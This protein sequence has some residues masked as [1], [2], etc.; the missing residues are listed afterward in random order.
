LQ[1]LP[2]DAL[3]PELRGCAD[4]PTAGLGPIRFV[5]LIGL[6]FAL[7]GLYFMARILRNAAWL[8]GTTL[9]VRAVADN[10]LIHHL[11]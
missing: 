9:R 10:P 7:I 4:L 11:Q 8:D 3:P 5:G 6:P 2:S 1:G